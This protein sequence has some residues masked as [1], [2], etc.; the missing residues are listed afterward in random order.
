MRRFICA[1]LLVSFCLQSTGIAAANAQAGM[2]TI[3]VLAQ[4]RLDIQGMSNW[5][6]QTPIFAFIVNPEQ[7]AAMHA[8]APKRVVAPRLDPSVAFHHNLARPTVSGPGTHGNPPTM[9]ARPLLPK[10]VEKLQ[11]PVANG[12]AQ[13]QS[14]SA[15]RIERPRATLPLATRANVPRTRGIH[16]MNVTVSSANPTGV[17]SWWTYRGGGLPG[18]G[19]YMINV[20]NGNL[21]TETTDVDV[22]ERGMNLTFQRTYNSLSLR[23]WNASGTSDDGSPT[24]GTYG[25]GWTNTFDTH[26]AVNSAGGI[27]VFD[28]DGARYDYTSSGGGCLASPAGVHTTLCWDGG[29]G[30]FWT[31]KNGTVYYYYEPSFGPGCETWASQDPAY[32][33]RLYMIFGR[34]NN[35][36]IRLTYS[37][38]GGNATS[39]SNL[40]QIVAQHQNGQ[41]LTLAFG[42]LNGKILLSSLTRPDGQQI[43][44]QYAPNPGGTNVFSNLEEVDLPGNNAGIIHQQYGYYSNTGQ[45]YWANSPRWFSSGAGEGSY[46]TFYYDSS[47]RISAVQLYGWANFTPSDG[48]GAVLQPSYPNQYGTIRYSTLTYS[49]GETQFSD[50]DGH[51]TNWFFDSSGRV[52]QTQ[53]WTG[54]LWLTAY[55]TWNSDNALTESVDPRGN[56]VD[57]AYDSNGNIIAAALPAISTSQGTFRPT[58]LYSYDRTNN[59]NNI[60]AYCD[61]IRTHALGQDWTGNPG[62]SD[63]LCLNQGGATRYSWD[64]SDSAEPFGR[65]SNTYTPLGYH[66]SL[67]YN[68]GAQSGDFGLPTAQSGDC[69]AQIDSTNRCPALTFSYDSLGN[70]TSYN[71]G[72]GAWA[73]S[74]DAM[75]RP[76]SSTDPDGVTGRVCYYA[77][78]QI[79][80]RQSALQYQMDGGAVCG[81][82]SFAMTYDVNGNEKSETHHYGNVAATTTKWYDGVDRLVEVQLPQ[83]PQDVYQNPWITRYLYDISQGGTV[84]FTGG[85]TQYY[86]AHGSLYKTQELL[87]PTSTWYWGLSKLNNN[88]FKDTKGTA[89]DALDR[90]VTRYGPQ[91]TFT[92]DSSPSTYG[93]L[94]QHCNALNICG[95]GTYDNAG[96]ITQV[97]YN[98]GSTP[99][100]SLSFD[101]DNRVV[102][103][104]SSAFGTQS[105][106]FNA[107]GKETQSVEPSGGGVTSPATLTYHYYADGR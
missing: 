47:S 19:E 54:S 33:G 95:N 55:A 5:L 10:D 71:T 107:D 85:T 21:V 77:N 75:N 3:G 86:S 11:L 67:S 87:A 46:T 93:A 84:S 101:P 52:T 74:Y 72:N 4:M 97:S 40:T 13:V 2:G 98:D 15:P 45:M 51:A 31:K 99:S 25:S 53:N 39:T 104:T 96:E 81:A 18:V 1:T 56:A 60:V 7:Y 65:I 78:G 23:D 57:Y 38:A 22:A 37:W 49:T 83:D 29:C 14:I 27:S 73:F 24:P 106:S 8:A 80:A 42:S 58:S 79:S 34:N 90:T 44:Y 103:V 32:A 6:F 30:Y 36:W 88:I 64:Y 50:V 9:L 63:S 91:E 12:A 48:M 59:A 89:R 82:H 61:A 16:T 76:T 92:Y 102:G 69:I 20:A 100:E 68:S 66:R 28:T 70:L 62:T 35:N 105:Y 94:A 43:I 26:L 41:S 17:N